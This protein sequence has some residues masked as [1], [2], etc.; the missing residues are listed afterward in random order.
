[1]VLQE[2][3]ADYISRSALITLL[4]RKFG[5]NYTIKQRGGKWVLEIP[6]YLSDVKIP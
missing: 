4:R 3:D 5:S 2:V 1:M 6:D